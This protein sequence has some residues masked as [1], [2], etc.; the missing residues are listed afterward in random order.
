VAQAPGHYR[1]TQ[2]GRKKRGAAKLIAV[3]SL[4]LGP[5]D[6]SV[7]LVLGKYDARK[8]LTL[9]A[10]GLV[11]ADGTRAAEIVIDL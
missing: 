6:T 2:P 9:T 3:R 11:G 7:T 8:P 10:T 4:A 1:V 5:G